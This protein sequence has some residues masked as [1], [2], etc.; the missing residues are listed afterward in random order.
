MAD[1]R[2]KYGDNEEI[3]T[4]QT[5][6]N[7]A[8]HPAASDD[9]KNNNASSDAGDADGQGGHEGGGNTDEE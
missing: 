7:G 9:N 4:L 5:Q 3:E 1:D 8:N 6:E 2:K